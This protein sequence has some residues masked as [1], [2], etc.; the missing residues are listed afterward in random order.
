MS[1]KI[2]HKFWGTLQLDKDKQG[3]QPDYTGKGKD[4]EGRDI[5]IA[6]WVTTSEK[7]NKYLSMK[8]QYPKT[9]EDIEPKKAPEPIK[10]EQEDPD[11]PF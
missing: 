2:K 1:E 3:K 5:E 10:K 7:G 8:M 4:I 9:E 6:A 11:L